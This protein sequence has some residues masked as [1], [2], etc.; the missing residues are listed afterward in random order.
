MVI[1]IEANP[2]SSTQRVSGELSISQS[3]VGQHLCNL[4]KSIESCLILHYITK[5]LQNFWLSQEFE[6]S[7]IQASLIIIWNL[8]LIYSNMLWSPSEEKSHWL[9]LNDQWVWLVWILCL[10]AYQSLWNIQCQKHPCRITA[11][12]EFNP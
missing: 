3:C 5:I 7:V 4:T 9:V 10:M 11:M 12:T 6:D 1:A 8:D 2:A